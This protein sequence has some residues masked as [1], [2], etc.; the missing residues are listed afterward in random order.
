MLMELAISIENSGQKNKAALLEACHSWI[1]TEPFPEKTTNAFKLTFGKIPLKQA[2]VAARKNSGYF[3]YFIPGKSMEAR[4]GDL[5]IAPLF[6]TEPEFPLF[7]NFQW[8][9]LEEPQRDSSIHPVYTIEKKLF[10][11]SRNRVPIQILQGDELLSGDTVYISLGI[12]SETDLNQVMVEDQQSAAIKKI[13][14]PA[15]EKTNSFSFL[16]ADAPYSTSFYIPHLPKGYHVIEY[17]VKMAGAGTYSMGYASIQLM[18]DESTRA[19]SLLS[20][21]QL[22]ANK[23]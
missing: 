1:L 12:R 15:Y 9:Y 21:I 6:T 10:R 8:Q 4:M 17:P 22:T 18:T 14:I 2:T 3:S 13:S 7:G 23:Q 5:T 20:N 11:Y 16:T 19:Y